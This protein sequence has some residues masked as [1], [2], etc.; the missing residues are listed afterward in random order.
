MWNLWLVRITSGITNW[1]PCILYFIIRLDNEAF[2]F[3]DET[4]KQLFMQVFCENQ[5][6]DHLRSFT[7]S[8]K[9]LNL[10]Y[11]LIRLSS[12]VLFRLRPLGHVLSHS[13]A[14]EDCGIRDRLSECLDRLL[15]HLHVIPRRRTWSRA[16]GPAPILSFLILRGLDIRHRMAGKTENWIFLT[17]PTCGIH[18]KNLHPLKKNTKFALELSAE[19]SSLLQSD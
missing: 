14:E 12:R 10:T 7:R 18:Q 9:F 4:Y 5:S 19:N 16:P 3:G 6:T 13:E 17:I 11:V 1:I 2:F 15:S 8:R